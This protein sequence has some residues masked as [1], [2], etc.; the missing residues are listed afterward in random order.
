MKEMKSQ[1]KSKLF[2]KESSVCSALSL[3][4]L[5]KNV[6]PPSELLESDTNSKS[7]L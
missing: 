7:K 1:K 4:C 6:T 3:D 5:Y 2:I